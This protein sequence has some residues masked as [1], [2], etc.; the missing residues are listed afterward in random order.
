MLEMLKETIES[1]E[2]GDEICLGRWVFGSETNAGPAG[3]PRR[4]S[5]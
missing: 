1:A 5:V 4:L 2:L 3:A